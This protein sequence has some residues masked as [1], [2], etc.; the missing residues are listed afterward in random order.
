MNEDID[1]QPAAVVCP[2]CGEQ[3]D[4]LSTNDTIQETAEWQL[5]DDGEMVA[6]VIDIDAEYTWQC[7][8]CD[9][10][11]A[12]SWEVAELFLRGWSLKEIE[13]LAKEEAVDEARGVFDTPPPY[14]EQN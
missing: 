5:D 4:H 6:N 11:I 13:E 7:P 12:Y 8:E 10:N 14:W 3:I 9:H 1:F 2:H